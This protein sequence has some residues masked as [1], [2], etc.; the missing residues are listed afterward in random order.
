MRIGC[1]GGRKRQVAAQDRTGRRDTSIAGILRRI[2]RGVRAVCLPGENPIEIRSELAPEVAVAKLDRL[3]G[4]S[5]GQSL[6]GD[7]KSYH[8]AGKTIAQ[9]QA[10]HQDQGQQQD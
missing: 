1:Q 4:I 9:A 3:Y 7:A 6:H 10:V 5:I 2:C 8:R